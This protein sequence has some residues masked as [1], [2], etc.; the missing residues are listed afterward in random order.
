METKETISPSEFKEQFNKLKTLGECS[1]FI[2]EVDAETLIKLR[3]SGKIIEK[4]FGLDMCTEHY[5]LTIGYAIDRKA[6][7]S[8]KNGN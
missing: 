7:R 4:Y 5:L 2:N 8:D 3:D 6:K 1:D